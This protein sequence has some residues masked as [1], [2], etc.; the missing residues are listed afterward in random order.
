MK[1]DAADGAGFANSVAEQQAQASIHA[2]VANDLVEYERARSYQ[3][4]A[5]AFLHQATRALPA[6]A[7]RLRVQ[8]TLDADLGT[9]ILSFL[10]VDAFGPGHAFE[11][12]KEFE[13]DFALARTNADFDS[14][15]E[16][17][18]AEHQATK[19]DRLVGLTVLLIAAAFFF[20]L[21][22]VSSR[23]STA[24]LYLWGGLMVLLSATGLLVFVVAAT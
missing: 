10:N 6:D 23:R 11:P 14:A 18:A 19:A 22:Q 8:A 4:Q 9:R 2:T 13:I 16:F 7:Q 17:A 12:N 20:T 21:A 24:K 3:A 5:T 1:R 15:T